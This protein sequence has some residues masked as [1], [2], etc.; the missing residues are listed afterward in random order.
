LMAVKAIAPKPLILVGTG[1]QALIR[2]FL[3]E[4]GA[5]TPASQQNLLF[6]ASDVRQAVK[7]LP[8]AGQGME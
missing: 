5:F 8:A 1:W 4:F 3:D 6:F 7:L 2:T